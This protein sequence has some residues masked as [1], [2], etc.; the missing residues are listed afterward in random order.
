MPT[1]PE[2]IGQLDFLSDRISTQVRTVSLGV[3]ALTWGLLIGESESARALSRQWKTNLIGIGGTAIV[4]MFLDFLQ[5][6][7]GFR[8]NF[9]LRAKM[10]EASLT[11]ADYDEKALTWRLRLLFFRAKQWVLAFAVLWLLYVLSRWSF[12]SN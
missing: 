4:A 6:A 5:Y 1:K 10:N 3:L 11:E 7:A 8:D 12:S 2:V 9:K